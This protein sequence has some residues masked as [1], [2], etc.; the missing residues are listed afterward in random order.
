MVHHLVVDRVARIWLDFDFF[1]C[2]QHD[3]EVI[4]GRIIW[5]GH[6]SV[7]M[8]VACCPNIVVG[9]GMPDIALLDDLYSD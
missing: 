1:D 3:L 9:G 5:Q 2:H 7:S 6:F 4:P 8:E